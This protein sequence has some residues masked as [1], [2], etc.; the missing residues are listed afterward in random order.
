MAYFEATKIKDTAGSLI[1]P[2]TEATLSSIDDKLPA[3]DEGRLPVS[4]A[5]ITT[6]FRDAFE[7]YTPG[8]RWTEVKGSGDLIYVD[9]NAASASYL[10]ISKNPLVVDTESEVDS[11]FTFV[12]P[13]EISVGVALSQ[14]TLGQQFS[15][16]VIDTGTALASVS[17]IAIASI[18]QT[19][20]VLT[21]DTVTDHGLSVGKSVGIT[22]C[23]NQ[24]V[25]YPAL[26]VAS[27]PSP[28]QFTATAGPGGT[29]TSQSIS[30]PAGA[31]GSVYFRER[32]SRTQNGISQVFENPTVT[33]ASLY[34]RS[35]SGD[36]LPSGTVA[37]NH[38]V[39]AGTTAPVALVSAAYQYAWSPTTE[40]RI[41]AQA[42]RV[43]WADSAV[44]TVAGT[45]SR[46][47]R[48]QVIPNPGV[49]YRLRL[50][51]INYKSLTVPNA[52][53]VSAVKTGNM[54]KRIL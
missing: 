26:V 35:E 5:N 34:L 24:L 6:K 33:N 49:T 8:V 46:L 4:T 48:T 32:M 28:R 10:V 50:R 44:D 11:V 52:Q 2:A 15:I 16:E 7:S 9:G 14:R 41:L 20:T 36:V 18:T 17:D 3:L 40:Y 27:V 22:G 53:I 47:M 37:G 29:I 38:S 39:T 21:V 31:K 42:D 13:T 45:T 1:N 12:M 30:N 19:T 43:Q 51:A 54:D 23:S 25:N